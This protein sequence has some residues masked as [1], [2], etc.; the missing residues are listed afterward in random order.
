MPG[1]AR[2][3]TGASLAAI[4]LSV[5]SATAFAQVRFNVPSE[6]LARALEDLASQADLNVYFDRSAVSGLKAR[7]LRA[8]LTPKAAFARLLAGTRLA[9]VYVDNDTVRVVSKQQARELQKKVA[10]P[11]HP[12]TTRGVGKSAVSGHREDPQPIASSVQTGNDP[13]SGT[14]TGKK[15]HKEPLQ[16]VVVTG[17]HLRGRAPPSTPI[18]SITRRQIQQSGYQTVE[19]VMD[20]LPE[21]FASVGSAPGSAFL[22]SELN[23]GNIANGAAVDLMGLGVD[24]TLV[25]VNGHRLAP[26]GTSGAFTDVSVIP[27]SAVKRIDIMTGGASAIYG[28]DAIGGVVNYVLR[29]HENGA[30]TSVEYGS[31]TRGG[32]KDYRAVQSGGL[33]WSTGHAFIS[34]EFQKQTPLLAADRAFSHSFGSAD[35]LASLTQNSLYGIANDA[36]GRARLH[37]DTFLSTRTGNYSASNGGGTVPFNVRTRSTQY[38][39]GMGSSIPLW[40]SW[41]GKLRVSYGGNDTHLSDRY[42]AN[43][44]QSTLLTFNGDMSGTLIKLATGPIKA[45]LGGQFRRERFARHYGGLFAGLEGITKNRNVG[46]LYAETSIP[47]LPFRRGSSKASA[48]VLDVAARYEHYSDFGSSFNPRAGLAWTPV[49]ALRMRATVSTAFKP[50][51]F[52]ELYGSRYA[53][54][55]NAPDS[56]S[57]SGVAPILQTEGSNPSLKA[58]RSTEWTLGMDLKPALMPGFRLH[59][60]YFDIRFRD[61][62][63]SPNVVYLE[64]LGLGN[65]SPYASY[66]LHQPPVAVLSALTQAP[67]EYVNYT[68]FPG[69]G[70][71]AALSDAVAVLDDSL[72]NIGIT[73]I[74][75]VN[76]T[77]NYADQSGQLGYYIG[78]NTVYLFHYRNTAV[79]GATPV[80]VLSTLEHPVNFKG[81]VT[82]GVAKGPWSLN[83]G[84][85]YVNHYSDPTG[86][87]PVR[88]SSWSTID[89]QIAYRVPKRHLPIKGLQVALSC[90]NCL[91]RAPPAVRI[92]SYPFGYDPTNANPMGRFVSLT[93]RAKW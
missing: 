21:N 19:Q 47:L 88:I 78:I 86:P 13:G 65:A 81:R 83:G 71:P 6:P 91:D 33:N 49:H 15:A 35:L 84:V 68:T 90:T 37:I 41:I 22:S 34:Y 63:A 25:L 17:T 59:A 76:D 40:T 18:I 54:L 61:R 11:P 1:H 51:N 75:G 58:E 10:R 48:L 46:A 30:E 62:I 93:M 3:R 87:V 55:L 2:S 64:A 85:N 69:F 66:I 57:L 20:A 77:L 7:A 70:P 82:M 72:Q 74:N 92:N 79:R 28:A 56:H 53:L 27:L 80:D 60:T 32:L 23:A 45:A 9:A 44:A 31:V 24:S 50:P 4:L 5:F 67:T 14:S 52:Y 89:L 39:V 73:R 36:V 12:V 26:S 16:E 38:S 43:A 8:A 42:G 29:S